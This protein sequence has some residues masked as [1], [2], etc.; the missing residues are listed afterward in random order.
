MR[1]GAD[2]HR[3]CNGLRGGGSGPKVL[4]TEQWGERSAAGIPAGDT[5]AK[6][7][8]ATLK[9]MQE[10]STHFT[11]DKSKNCNDLDKLEPSLRGWD[12]TQLSKGQTYYWHPKLIKGM[13]RVSFK[14]AKELVHDAI[15]RKQTRA[16][17][18]FCLIPRCRVGVLSML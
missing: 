5:S 6:H 9:G 17:P 8:A 10:R 15:R 18:F 12:F 4:S 3:T 2:A 14:R 7:V 11:Q 1:G 13:K 16:S